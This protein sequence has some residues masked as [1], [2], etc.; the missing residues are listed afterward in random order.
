MF[1]DGR[2]RMFHPTRARMELSRAGDLPSC[3][4]F[5]DFCGSSH[6]PLG[7]TQASRT[8]SGASGASCSGFGPSSACGGTLQ[9]AQPCGMGR[10]YSLLIGETIG[11]SLHFMKV[12]SFCATLFD[13]CIGFV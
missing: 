12:L 3:R 13:V 10:R 11:K 9:T 2:F 5:R 4:E 6:P 8:F 7:W 1:H